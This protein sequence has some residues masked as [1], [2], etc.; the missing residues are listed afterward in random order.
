M[1][2]RKIASI[3]RPDG[4][5]ID[6]SL[7]RVKQGSSFRN[8]ANVYLNVPGGDGDGPVEPPPDTTGIQWAG[9]QPGLIYLGMSSPEDE[10]LTRL[11]EINRPIGVRRKF[12][13]WTD[14]ASEDADF[15]SSKLRREI[16][17]PSFAGPG[18]AS[19]AWPQIA[20]GEHDAALRA[21]ARRYADYDGSVIVTYWHEASADGTE[22][23]GAD[24]A[25]AMT[26]IYN[27]WSNEVGSLKAAGITFCPI[28]GDWLFN[29]SNT[30]QDPA[31]W[32]KPN[33]LEAMAANDTFV[34]ADMYHNAS[35]VG[36]DVRIPRI[37][38][39][40]TARGY[41]FM[42]G[43]GETG[44]TNASWP[45]PPD[46]ATFW[47][48]NWSWAAANTNRIGVISY[49]NSARNSKPH[50]YW[51]LDEDGLPNGAKMVAFRNSLD[52]A[53][54]TRLPDPNAS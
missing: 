20:A 38:D 21:R 23:Q 8:V 39:W 27:V 47:A 12:Y 29:P 32:F 30:G 2:L 49:F 1:A 36:F 24:W 40:F 18:G 15:A 19:L 34:G 17:W 6:M 14:A 16:F 5:P 42:I 54:F 7:L 51:P 10:F 9:H 37:L 52:S 25:N 44:A 3:S 31:N 41:T 11:A 28:Q 45:D 35:Q 53:K 50:V 13:G 4:S 48:N 46:A 26:K 22:T 33:L 43:I